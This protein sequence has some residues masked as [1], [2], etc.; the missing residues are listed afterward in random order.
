MAENNDLGRESE[1]RDALTILT[2]QQGLFRKVVTRLSLTNDD[3]VPQSA[4]PQLVQIQF[5][6]FG[7]PSSVMPVLPHEDWSL[8][9]PWARLGLH[10]LVLDLD[11][12]LLN[13]NNYYLLAIPSQAPT[14][15][16][17]TL[18]H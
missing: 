18:Q 6:T 17:W 4:K 16:V 15:L 2:Q 8:F 14:P 1:R 12:F 7:V 10:L 9:L 13:Q 5:Q 3:P 11:V